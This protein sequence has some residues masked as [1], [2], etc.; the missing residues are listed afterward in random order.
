M[1]AALFSTCKYSG[2]SLDKGWPV[3]G[4]VYS[5]EA[6]QESMQ[7]SLDQFRLADEI[8]FD[9]VTVAEHHYAPFSLTPNPMVMA[10]ALTQVIKRAKIALLGADIPILNPVRV[11]EEFAMLD[12]MT[13]GRV[14]A[15]MLR[16][17]P[18]EY[19]TYNINPA[20]SRA[21]F[22]EAL[23]LIKMAWTQT[24]PFGWQG[25]YYEYR[26]IS[27]WPRCV[28]APH[29]KIYMSGSSP[30]AG[31][32]AAKNRVGLGFAVTTVP[33]AA[34][35]V[36]HYRTQAARYGWEPEPEDVI[37][38]VAVHVGENDDQALEDFVEATKTGAR[39]GLTMAN[40]GLE[41]AIAETG[42]YGRDADMQRQRLMPR[43]LQERID[44]G[45]ILLG[46]PETVLK[47]IES[48]KRELGAGVIDLTVAHQMGAKTIRSIELL[49]EK[50]LPRI[51]HW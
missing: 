43:S 24:E 44:Q 12:T 6:A 51:R 4:S 15:G 48:I 14:V 28:Q 31:E 46:G 8:G 18:N 36:T 47:Q 27:I 2:P 49:G 32:F 13:G 26:T 7:Q 45:Q 50:V 41:S 33:L 37:Y 10:G 29:P 22:E 34:K 35:A 5:R 11:A 40:R 42:Y 25:R 1:K 16:G 30:E 17:T 23:Q 3:S 38:R 19:V 39:T 9:W 21:R 20:E